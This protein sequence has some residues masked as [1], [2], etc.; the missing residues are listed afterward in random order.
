MNE[1]WLRSGSLHEVMQQEQE[2]SFNI[3]I[4]QSVS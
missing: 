2:Q 3:R 1:D 4:V